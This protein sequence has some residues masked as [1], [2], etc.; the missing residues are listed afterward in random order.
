MGSKTIL[1]ITALLGFAIAPGLVE[2]SLAVAQPLA[3]CDATPP[4]PPVTTIAPQVPEDVCI[5]ADSQIDFFEIDFF[6]DYS[7][8]AFLALVWP[9]KEG[10]RGQ[11]DVQV[12]LGAPGRRLVF[13]TYKA[14]WEVFQPGGI[15]PA[16]WN[17]YQRK[18][19]FAERATKNPCNLSDIKFGDLVL[20][21]FS[22]FDNLAQAGF[23]ELVGPLVAQNRTYARY[24]TGFN[25]VGFA[26]IALE[27]LYLFNNVKSKVFASGVIT[28][29]A[30]WIDMAGIEKPERYY[31]REAYLLDPESNTCTKKLVGLVGLHIVQKTPSRPQ[32][33][34]ST[35]EHI[36]NV[37]PGE[38]SNKLAFNAGD[39]KPMPDENEI[40]YP[41]PP[42]PPNPFNVIRKKPI[43][44]RTQ[45][46]NARY[47]Q[48][49]Q[50]AG[51]P[52]QFYQL[53]MTQWPRHPNDP[54]KDGK[55]NNTV[56][57]TGAD[58]S[59]ANTTL[60]T[61]DQTSINTGCMNCHNQARK[62]AD[63]I[64]SLLT[65]A[66]LSPEQPPGP[67]AP[68][69]PAAE[70][71]RMLTVPAAQLD[72]FRELKALMESGRGSR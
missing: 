38:G 55:P 56:P 27:K 14:G 64:Y 72:V 47:R 57:G 37:P 44:S 23:G 4:N 65:R 3:K 32:W 34:W 69:P 62:D 41:P 50:D 49:L 11:P 67:A 66:W 68:P 35:F 21:A 39:E 48:A 43:H 30:A 19:S 61:F 51:A 18:E 8:R 60:E 20:A 71:S 7:W 31:T 12:K 33:I 40:N 63:F 58:T 15:T 54:S 29:K 70:S 24:L 1:A 6:D 25:E 59:F 28:T 53:V 36:D 22:K 9:A 26:Q 13:E 45:E 16:A 5:P 10:Q 46:T 42:Q 2:S 17:E 52:W